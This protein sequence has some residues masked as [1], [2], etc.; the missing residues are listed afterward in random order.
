MPII[1]NIDELPDTLVTQTRETLQAFLES[2]IDYADYGKGTANYDL[3]IRP[4]SILHAMTEFNML[5]LR[6]SSTFLGI[7]KFPEL[8]TPEIMDALLSNY[9]IVRSGGKM[10]EGT[11]EIVISSNVLTAIP[12]NSI[13]V[14]GTLK[15]YTQEAFVGVT[16]Q[17]LVVNSTDRLIREIADGAYAFTVDVVAEQEGSE[18]QLDAGDTLVLQT[19]PS[20]YITSR[21]AYDFATGLNEE[22]NRELLR[23][24]PEGLANRT[25]GNRTNIAA[26]IRDSYPDMLNTAVIGFG[27]PEMH[28]DQAN[29]FRT[30]YGG[31]SDVYVQTE[32]RP[33]IV[34][35]TKSAILV[36]KNR[37]AWQMFFDRDEFAGVYKI[38]GIYRTDQTNTLGSLAIE[39]E[40]RGVDD[41][42]FADA[43]DAYIPTIEEYYQAAFSRYQTNTIEFL[44]PNADTSEM[45]E[46][47]TTQDY[48]VDV[49]VLKD[50]AGIQDTI[51]SDY[52]VTNHRYDDLVRAPIPCIV[53]VSMGIRLR[54]GET[55]NEA[56]LK[57]G[58]ADRV[59]QLGF[60]NVLS[61]S[62]IIDAAHGFLGDKSA[63]VT[64]IDMLGEVIS[65]EDGS[66]LIYRSA[67]ELLVQENDAISLSSRKMMFFLSPS[68]IDIFT[69]VA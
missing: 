48:Y 5:Q 65:P 21:A 1:I 44:D 13:F 40:V 30:S 31:K 47:I 42:P 35:L 4:Y 25:P 15:F 29:L 26:L 38:M 66:S 20:N 14:A 49:L 43:P 17:S 63:V 28:R 34:R 58:V 27:Q 59:N 36:N 54:A 50:I 24:L 55:F 6:G 60:R 45:T 37:S 32:P 62:Y 10:A 57:A 12:S 19:P 18:Y 67:T 61:S 41:S 2:A 16:D 9:R 69:E 64:P 3:V 53:S 22:T 56:G 8:A 11:V 52:W 46:M 33:T 7:S 39:S 23:R 51:L 68:N